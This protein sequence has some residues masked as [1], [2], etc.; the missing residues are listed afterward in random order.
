[1]LMKHPKPHVLP[2]SSLTFGPIV[3]EGGATF[4]VY[5]HAATAVRVLLYD[6]PHDREP[7]EKIEMPA[8]DRW[9][10]VWQCFVRG[11][12]PGQLYHLQCDGPRD[13]ERGLWF[14][15]GARLI[16]PYAP[17]LVG[18][19]QPGAD[20]I[21]RPPKGL[22][23]NHEFDWE[24][25]KRPQRPLSET[26]IYELHV[27]GFTRSPTSQVKHPGTYLG[28]IEKIPYLLSLGVTAVEL[29]PVQE[30]PILGPDGKRLARPNYWGYDPLAWFA[31]HRGFA[32]SSLPGAQVVEFKQMVKAL[33]AAG[34]EVILDV[35]FNHTCE[36]NEQGPV[37]SF[38]GLENPVYYLLHHGGR[39]YTNYSGCGNTV[40]C[41]HPV[42]QRLILDCLRSW[43][44]NYHVDGFRFDLA[45]ILSRNP[46][47]TLNHRAPLVEQIAE[48]PLLQ[49]TK[50]IAEPWD[51]GG[52]Y[53][54]GWFGGPRWAEWNGKYRDDVRRFWRGDAG[55]L[56]YLTTR[57]AGSSDLYER[58][59][60][61][62]TCS[63]NFVTCHDGYTLNDLVSYLRKHNE[64]NGEGNQ[65]GDN[66][67]L[68]MNFGVEGRTDDPEVEE[69]RVRQIKNLLATLLLSQGVPMLL[70]GDECRRTQ[71]GNNNAYCHDSRISWFD[72]S[73]VQE[74]RDLFRFCR[75]LI[76]FRRE[77]PTVRRSTFLNGQHGRP[78]V[79]WSDALG[80][81][82]DWHGRAMT[83][84]CLLA[85]PPP[86]QDPEHR[87]RDL[88]LLMNATSE[89]QDFVL[90]TAVR[91]G[92]WR[93]F[94]DTAAAPPQDVFPMRDGP[95]PPPSGRLIL[96]TRSLLCYVAVQPG[97]EAR[98][99]P[100]LE[101]P[102]RGD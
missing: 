57:L 31:P 23:V 19:F 12:G 30:F 77:Q 10:D 89:P 2:K 102:E 55:T 22:V 79:E 80:R 1:M 53:Q 60:R 49:G 54:V 78:D 8:R 35:V 27:R 62:P 40:N 6:Y 7:A 93:L 86:A 3:E 97:D 29:M 68:S 17:A 82:V 9:G 84:T 15:G 100:D 63:V 4:T 42:V 41:N 45:S 81:P 64:A 83:L 95:A 36:G 34:I 33:H 59:Q 5:S 58:T 73:L 43:V 56:R 14:D 50:I 85:A 67:N 51:A 18:D 38:K 44:L 75:A 48:D 37:L 71:R 11:V 16:D 47:G 21:V 25:D 32:A 98:P 96:P 91:Q 69:A 52:A 66:N 74:H 72:W 20:G 99:L 13:P 28:L 70:A 90:P 88:L 94:V 65:D 24:G 92:R 61:S 87:G 46:D 101:A 39:H 76:R 26:I